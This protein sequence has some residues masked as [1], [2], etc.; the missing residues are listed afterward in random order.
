[1]LLGCQSLPRFG[2]ELLLNLAAD[3]S[4]AALALPMRII[5]ILDADHER[6]QAG[7]DR[8]RRYR[9]RGVN[10]QTH[11]IAADE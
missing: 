6:R 10:P 5:E 1:V 9:E 7:R 4:V 3:P 8:F 2:Y 11:H